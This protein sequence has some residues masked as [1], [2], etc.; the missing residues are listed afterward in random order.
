MRYP[1]Q[2]CASV[3]ACQTWDWPQHFNVLVIAAKNV[4]PSD[5]ISLRQNI[6]TTLTAGRLTFQIL[7][8]VAEFEEKCCGNGPVRNGAGA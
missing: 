3:T 7:G 5:V 8:A 6:D 1:P 4:E 2:N